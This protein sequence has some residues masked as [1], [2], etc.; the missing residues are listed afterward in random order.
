MAHNQAWVTCVQ[1][2]VVICVGRCR[3]GLA[4]QMVGDRA[5]KSDSMGANRSVLA[6]F[7]SVSDFVSQDFGVLGHP[8]KSQATGVRNS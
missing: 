5:V 3:G 8:M 7:V 4:N 6:D 2:A 1:L